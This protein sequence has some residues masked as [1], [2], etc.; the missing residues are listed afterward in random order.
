MVKIICDRC[1]AEIPEAEIIRA[2]LYSEATGKIDKRD[3]CGQCAKEIFLPSVS[4]EPKAEILADDKKVAPEVTHEA[5]GVSESKLRRAKKIAKTGEKRK[6]THIDA[7]KLT[8]LHKAGWK[9]K[10]IADE[11]GITEEQVANTLCRLRRNGS[12]V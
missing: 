8:A 4:K 5:S 3:L 2:T 12:A 6:Y 9:V 11:M 7:G 10:Q 1:G